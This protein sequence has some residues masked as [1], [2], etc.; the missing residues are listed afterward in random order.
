MK[1]FYK[2]GL[3][4]LPLILAT[5]AFSQ[6]VN[7]DL[8]ADGG[9]STSGM[10]LRLIALLT[11]L[12]L[13]PSILI[14]V[15]CFTRMIV[16]L[17][18]LKNAMGTQQTPPANVIVSLALFLTMFVMAPTFEAAYQ[19]GIKP[20]INEQIDETT[21]FERTTAPFKK[22]MLENVRKKDILLFLDLSNS[23][24]PESEDDLSLRVLIPA[25]M[26]SELKRA[27]EIGFLLFI[28]FLVVDMVVASI[29][30]AMGMMMLPPVIVSLPFKIIF[31]VLI[32]G[33]YL[34]AGSLVRSYGG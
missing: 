23:E 30:M 21:A 14:M 25:F 26:I 3:F 12:S 9:G 29:L 32:D 17:S 18:F 2:W 20:L 33:W 5:P 8:G 6:A 28:P 10:V 13:A 19:T 34:V 4:L 16:V 11:I 31:F 7:I 22:F 1:K 15:T 27:F 24:Q